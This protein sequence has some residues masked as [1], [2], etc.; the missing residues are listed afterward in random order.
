VDLADPA[1]IARADRA[2][3]ARQNGHRAD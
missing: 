1:S 3:E 2:A